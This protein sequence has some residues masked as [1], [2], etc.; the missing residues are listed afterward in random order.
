M[1]PADLL[2]ETEALAA[3]IAALAVFREGCRKH[4]WNVNVTFGIRGP[5]QRLTKAEK[6][7][8]AP[9]L[10]PVADPVPLERKAG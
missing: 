5:D 2:G 10:E 3:F 6:D 1:T 7:A 9:R 4:W 8:G